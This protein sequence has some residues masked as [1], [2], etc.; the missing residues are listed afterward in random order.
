MT[1]TPWLQ[2]GGS[3]LHLEE[4][5][6]L[7]ERSGL[8]VPLF[9]RLILESCVK[10][11]KVSREEQISFQQRF[12]AENGLDNAE[13]LNAWLAKRSLTEEQA[14]S[15][16]LE[17]LKLDNFKKENLLPTLKEYFWKARSKETALCTLFFVSRTKQLLLSCTSAWKRAMPHS[18]I[19]P[20]NI[21]S[22]LKEKQVV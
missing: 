9:R 8:L 22:D 10:N 6:S 3:A 18:P 20:R 21:R 19:F 11:I 1:L 16:I 12:L 15:N 5:P 13:K 7:L 14:S 17:A 4:L 2:F